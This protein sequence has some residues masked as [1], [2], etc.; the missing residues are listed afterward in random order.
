MTMESA[1]GIEKMPPKT[2]P[3]MGMKTVPGMGIRTDRNQGG[4]RS[5]ETEATQVN[6][7]QIV[8]CVPPREGDRMQ[9]QLLPNKPDTSVHETK[10]R[11]EAAMAHADLKRMISGLLERA[12]GRSATSGKWEE[13]LEFNFAVEDLARRLALANQLDGYDLRDALRARSL[14][15]D[16]A[17]PLH[18]A[19]R[20]NDVG[21]AKL[22]LALILR[23]LGKL[24]I[25]AE[26]LNKPGKLT[27]AEWQVLKTYPV[28]GTEVIQEAIGDP[29][30]AS[31]LVDFKQR[32]DGKGYPDPTKAG[33][34]IPLAARIVGLIDAYQAMTHDRPYR[35]ALSA[36]QAASELKK[37]AGTQFDP[38]IVDEFLKLLPSAGRGG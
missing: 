5:G 20:F 22:E 30:F 12:T 16:L 1:T 6:L 28:R 29:D 9:L 31:W 17:K 25:P 13:D 3:G 14:A 4:G 18:P 2:A 15:R 34:E 24:D 8:E 38:L 21:L 26:I 10:K 33:T 35:K 36:S 23:N 11:A 19:Y 37:G 7:P 27:A 32:W